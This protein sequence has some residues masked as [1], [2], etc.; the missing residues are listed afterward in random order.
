MT[1][2]LLMNNHKPL[3]VS[4]TKITYTTSPRN[5]SLFTLLKLVADLFKPHNDDEAAKLMT[6]SLLH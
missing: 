4:A 2:A 3:T 1:K 5:K 6:I